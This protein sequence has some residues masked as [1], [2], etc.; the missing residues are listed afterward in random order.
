MS[1]LHKGKVVVGMVMGLR[2]NMGV[3]FTDAALP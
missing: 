2:L 1:I 3:A